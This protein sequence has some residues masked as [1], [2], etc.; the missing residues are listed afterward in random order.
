MR[1]VLAPLVLFAA[2]GA[3]AATKTTVEQL[4]SLLADLHQQNKSDEAI[5]NRLKDVSLTEQLTPSTLA[6]IAQSKPGPLTTSQLRILV[7]ESAILPPPASE[8]PSDPT[9]GHDAQ[10]VIINRAI[11]YIVHQNSQ[12]PRLS[13]Q[14]ETTRF[15][16]A[17]NQ[18]QTET[19]TY[20]NFAGGNPGNAGPS[21]QYLKMQDAHTMTVQ[22]DKGIE[23]PPSSK[24]SR[25]AVQPGEISPSGGGLVL[26]V[27]LMDA[28]KN[29]LHFV[30]WQSIDGKKAAIFSFT[31]DKDNSH[32]KVSYCCFP[33]IENIGGAGS[34]NASPTMPAIMAQPGGTSATFKPFTAN[35]GY[36]GE[37]FIDPDTGVIVRV[38]TSAELKPTDIVQQENIRIDYGTANIDGK[39]LIVPK[40]SFTLTELAPN[41]DA[42][43][44]YS[45][46]RT[47][48]EAAYKNYTLADVPKER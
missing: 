14:K 29:D 7:A 4:Q 34:I 20:S 22:I 46:R 1:K 9:P 40:R 17:V 48:I 11:D 26:G 15:Q 39:P 10:T 12:L 45:L 23:L 44:K 24:K 2:L 13:A 5:A 31:V 25:P 43:V 32:Y 27:I 38:I 47:I 16:N 33:V 18:V 37:F 28:S 35:P 6:N 19:G 36:H 41:G 30:R 42:F 3:L 21:Q 8:L